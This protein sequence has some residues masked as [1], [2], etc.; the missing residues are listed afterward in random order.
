[1]DLLLSFISEED[2]AAETDEDKSNA[3]KHASNPL[4]LSFLLFWG[5]AGHCHEAQQVGSPGKGD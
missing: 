4:S 1:M 3:S 5:G 2:S